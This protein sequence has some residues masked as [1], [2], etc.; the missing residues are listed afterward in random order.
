MF[1]FTSTCQQLGVE[2][3]AYLQDVLT[4][5][6]ALLRD[7]WQAARQAKMVTPP[8]PATDV[9]TRPAESAC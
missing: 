8:S 5:L 1:R 7:R 3:L 6:G 4:R 2:P 9:S